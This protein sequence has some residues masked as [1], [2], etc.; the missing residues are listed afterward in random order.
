MAFKPQYEDS[1]TANLTQNY[2]K[3]T[4]KRKSNWIWTQSVKLQD[5]MC[6]Q[7]KWSDGKDMQHNGV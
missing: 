3:K 2:G 4:V 5:I 1:R 6:W 7:T